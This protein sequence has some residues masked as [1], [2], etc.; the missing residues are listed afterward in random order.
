MNPLKRININARF[1]GH[2]TVFVFLPNGPII[3]KMN[4]CIRIN[5]TALT[6]EVF[7]K[8]SPNPASDSKS[9]PIHHILFRKSL[10][11][12]DRL[13][14]I[15]VSPDYHYKVEEPRLN[16]IVIAQCIEYQKEKSEVVKRSGFIKA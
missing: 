11:L 15:G 7:R 10:E 14:V 13:L 16:P 8:S 3:N 5:T 6:R 2:T 12:G 9:G 1:H 4:V